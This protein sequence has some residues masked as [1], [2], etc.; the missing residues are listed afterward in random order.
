MRAPQVQAVTAAP[1]DAARTPSSAQE[2]SRELH[3]FRSPTN[4]R[5]IVEL[6]ITLVPFIAVWILTYLAWTRQMAWATIPLM[7]LASGFLVRLFLIQHDCGHGAFFASRRANDWVG[8]LLGVLTLTPYAHWRRTHAVHHATHGNLDRRGVGDVDTLTV[9]E[10]RA[11][12]RWARWRYRLYRNPIVMFGIGPAYVF[13]LANRI[14]AGFMRA[15]WQ[16]WIST[17]GTN[18]AIC[19]AAVLLAQA[20]GFRA[21]LGVHGPIVLLA[22]TAGVWLFYVQHQFERSHW[23]RGAGWTAREAALLGSSHYALPGVLRWFTANIGVHHVHHLSS[24]IPF[25][26]MPDVLDAHP[27]LVPMNRLTLGKSFACA[28]LAL[29]DER[30]GCLVR[31]A[32]LPRSGSTSSPEAVRA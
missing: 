27:S 28:A 17:M 30:S 4:R 16:P 26:R 19:L 11:R 21:L 10:Y 18:L 20:I 24:G 12:P 15:G 9:S 8:R 14:P 22:G 13:V 7:V 5:A 29:W 6:T 3:R 23:I 2:W 1:G 31:F 25:Y 32:D